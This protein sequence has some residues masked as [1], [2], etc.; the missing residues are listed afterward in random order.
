MTSCSPIF[1]DEI[2]NSVQFCITKRNP[3][4]SIIDDQIEVKGE[5]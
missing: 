1:L 4:I 5:G 3:F 2:L